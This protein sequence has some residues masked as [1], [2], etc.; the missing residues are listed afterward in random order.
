MSN[1][2]TKR[3]DKTV[4]IIMLIFH[5]AVPILGCAFVML[6]LNVQKSDFLILLMPAL[7][8][9]TF[10][11]R[12]LIGKATRYIF[13]CILPII[14]TIVT[15]LD[16]VG[17]SQ[18]YVCLTHGY[19][20]LMVLLVAYYDK[21][22]LLVNAAVTL[23]ANV[24]GLI[25]APA[26][27]YK[28]HTTLIAWIFI[29]IV[30]I[31]L[32]AV[33]LFVTYRTN[34]LFTQ[35]ENRENKISSVLGSVRTLSERLNAVGSILSVAS[36]SENASAEELAATSTELVRNSTA[37]SEK[38]DESMLNLNELRRWES[39]VSE[40]VKKVETISK[41]LLDKSEE[42]S[43]LLNDLHKVNGEVTQSMNA[44]TE[45]AKMLSGA[46][47][48]IG[49]TLSLISDISTSINLLS[50]NASI[51]AARA[52]EAGKGFA[53]V[54][55]E[56]GNLANSTRESL[57]EVET[58]VARVQKN[59]EKITSQID[60][61]SS[62]LGTQ[63][64]YFENMFKSMSEMKE[65]LNETAKT[66]TAMDD[67]Y[68]KQSETV[69]KT[70]SINEDIAENFRSANEMFKSINAM[71]ANNANDTAQVADQVSAIND[72]VGEMTGLLT[73]EG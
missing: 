67:S 10:L 26:G 23:V 69:S 61:N 15:V 35:V 65:L 27:F 50:L 13:A 34:K 57:K 12:K 40:N 68:S 4:D 39:E 55:A 62:R 31:V 14:G 3:D 59:I 7:A 56:V 63:T 11:L 6:F 72:M 9:V 48:E 1:C 51:E 2:S 44:T 33:C 30:Y 41:E 29:G 64:E 53:V 21:N 36:D 5:L 66:I 22:A 71:A 16:G 45:I 60:D 43:Q 47:S 58:V 25:A 19:F 18:G 54:A 37:L 70:I 52:G 46:V 24:I 42:N 20:V 38:T 17:E 8:I 28:L 49:G 73:N 32:L